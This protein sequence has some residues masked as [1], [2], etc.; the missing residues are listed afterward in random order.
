MDGTLTHAYLYR[1]RQVVAVLGADGRLERRFVYGL[2][3]HVP[4]AMVVLGEDGS[5]RW[6]R[7]ETDH[8]VSVRWAVDAETGEVVQRLEYD[9]WG[10]VIEDTSPGFQPFGFAGGL[11]DPLTGLV[12]FGVRDYDPEVGRWTAK[13]PILFA[14]GDS[15]LYGYCG[16]GSCKWGGSERACPRH[17]GGLGVHRMGR[18]ESSQ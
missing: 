15:N 10:R 6:Y 14:G 18:Q 11:Y 17:A 7:L 9:P 13:D 12:R 3:P 1:G 8:L 4:D 5:H 2:R 16:W